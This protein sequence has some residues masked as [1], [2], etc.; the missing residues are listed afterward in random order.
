MEEPIKRVLNML[1]EGK[2]SAVEAER[3]IRAIK[4]ALSK[5][6]KTKEDNKKSY[7]LGAILEEVFSSISETIG[8]SIEGAIQLSKNFKNYGDFHVDGKRVVKVNL[9]GGALDLTTYRGSEIKGNFKGGYSVGESSV[10]LW[11]TDSARLEVPENIDLEI[12]SLGGNANISGHFG[13]LIVST[14]GG[15]LKL[16][17]DFNELYGK[18]MGGTSHL[19]TPKAPL[20]I[21]IKQHGGNVSLPEELYQS[22]GYYIYGEINHKY[23][24]LTLFGGHFSL[25]FKEA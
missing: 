11:I 20:K 4:E 9:L 5:E 3:L 19:L 24:E 18:I 8:E 2:I 14:K 22:G 7:T 12:S 17:A 16:D 23:I 10:S 15:S 1:Y 25:S 6:E 21:K 13:S